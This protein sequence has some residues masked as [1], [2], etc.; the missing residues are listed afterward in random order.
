MNFIDKNKDPSIII[1][2]Y[3][4]RDNSYT[5]EYLDGTVS[6]YYC[7]ALDHEEKIKIK[8]LDQAI[9]RQNVVSISNLNIKKR[10]ELLIFTIS[11]LSTIA[12]LS[13]NMPLFSFF[14][15]L[16]LLFS[17]TKSLETSKKV[18]ELKKYELFFELIPHLDVINK[19]NFLRCIEF[20]TFYQKDLDINTLDEYSYGDIKTLYKKY[21]TTLK[22]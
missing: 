2:K 17:A 4:R 22:K 21:R 8:M 14:T 10:S 11:S 12:L 1:K 20:D 7:S 13:S 18:K 3:I 6:N 15:I 19:S 5:I 16:A 9:E